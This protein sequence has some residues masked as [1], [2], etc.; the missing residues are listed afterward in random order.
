MQLQ[1]K[2]QWSYEY[3][4]QPL[5]YNLDIEFWKSIGYKESLETDEV[6]LSTENSN[7]LKTLHCKINK[8]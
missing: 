6:P 2:H 4:G 5:P 7:F 8:P 3:I 1:M